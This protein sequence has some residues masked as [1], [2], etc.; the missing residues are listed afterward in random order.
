MVYVNRHLP[1][2]CSYSV[3]KIF[4]GPVYISLMGFL[5]ISFGINKNYWKM[6]DSKKNNKD[7]KKNNK[8]G[9]KVN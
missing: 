9:K 8:D 5:N 7:S 2:I 4:R 1:R 3:P 6:F